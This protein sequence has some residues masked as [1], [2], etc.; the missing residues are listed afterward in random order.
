MNDVLL[1]VGTK[2]GL[3]LGRSDDRIDWRWEGPHQAMQAIAAVA[4]DTRHSPARLLVGGRNEHWGPA[5]VTSDDLGNSWREEA[6]GSIEFPSDAGAALEQIWQLQPGPKSRPDEVWAGVEPAALFRST[7]GGQ[8]FGLIRALWDH[9]HRP[10]WH[11]GA[12]GQC[13]HT[14]IPHP[15]YP[16]RTLIAISTG[17]VYRTF[18]AGES[19]APSNTGIGTPF[20]P[21]PPPEF[22]QCVHKVA[23][24]PD[25]PDQL[26]L[27]NHGGVYRSSDWGSSWQPAEDGLPANFGFGLVRAPRPSGRFFVSPL[28]AD[29]ARFPVDGRAAIYRTDD[30]GDSWK[31][32]SAG[33]PETGFHTVVLRDALTTDDLDPVGVYFGTRSGEVW[34]SSTGGDRWNQVTAHLPDVLCVRAASV[35]TP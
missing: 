32:S 19:W 4:I 6:G 22:G 21:G 27:Q 1:A 3:F 13:L 14:V 2:K 28:T 15:D 31:D 17:G 16:E 8:T 12:G 5:V 7:D 10:Q 35:A 33:L 9:P 18:D 25:D 34:A 29:M 20:M 11:P 30:G 24:D 26:V 23:A